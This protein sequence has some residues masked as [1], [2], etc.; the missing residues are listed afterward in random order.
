M[1]P[2]VEWGLNCM[3]KKS[4]KHLDVV[5]AAI[6]RNGKVLAGCR[7]NGLSGTHSHWE[8]P[9]GKI[10]L[11]ETPEQALGREI[12]EELGSEVKVL[13][14]LDDS[15]HKFSG[16]ILRLRCYVCRIVAGEP[17]SFV[18]DDIKWVGHRELY[19]LD[20]GVADLSAVRALNNSGLLMKSFKFASVELPQSE[21]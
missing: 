6:L 14:L 3:Q 2:F 10:E 8:F 4:Y 11:D 16:H 7:R 21:L 17:K 13:S 9:G 12:L 19:D 20:W 18:H 5:A 1:Q 15:T